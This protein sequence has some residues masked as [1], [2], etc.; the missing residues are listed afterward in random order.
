M[1]RRVNASALYIVI[2]I[3]LVIGIVCASLVAGAYFY[4]IQFQKKARYDRL[5][6][7]LGSGINILLAGADTAFSVGRSFGLFGN[8]ADS[9]YLKKMPWGIYQVG[10]AEAFAQKDT[11]YRSFSIANCVDSSKWCCLYLADNDRPFSVSGKTTIRGNAFIPRGGVQTAFIANAAYQGDKRIIV[12]R[13]QNSSKSLPPLSQAVLASLNGYFSQQKLTEVALPKADSIRQSFILPTKFFSFGKTPV[14]LKDQSFEGNIVLLSDT[15]ITIDSTTTL[16]GV[17]IFA[18]AVLVGHGFKGRCQLFA[19]D[20]VQIG[21]NCRLTYPSAVGIVR[22][23]QNPAVSQEKIV[24]GDRSE[25]AGT[26]FTYEAGKNTL[27]PLIL[28]G[29]NVAITGQIYSQ[30]IVFLRDSLKLK[31][32]IFT[33]VFNYKSLGTLYEN[34]IVNAS[35][36]SKSLSPY[37]LSSELIPVTNNKQK[38]L[39]WLESN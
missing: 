4:K 8:E 27:K 10:I 19:T 2:V 28:P 22:F 9:V 24:I 30:G 16:N 34:Y 13:R 7:N 35:I 26:L 37:Y 31:G 11:L 6:D 39:Q 15:T 1:N 3:A 36:D 17:L 38:V 20:S 18:R 32:S 5:Q 23:V 21:N 33:G 12:G 14:T 29:K 25:F